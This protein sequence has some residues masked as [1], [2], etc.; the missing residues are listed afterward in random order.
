M[1]KTSRKSF[2]TSLTILALATEVNGASS[3]ARALLSRT[4]L[5]QFVSSDGKVE[6]V[7]TITGWSQ[8]RASIKT[9]MQ[10]VM[11][12]LPGAEKRCP[13]EMRVAQETDCGDYV[14]RFISYAAEPNGHVP[15]Y[16]LIPK[17][18]S[19]KAVKLPAILVLHQ[20]HP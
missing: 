20:T 10:E 5:L 18:A 6:S 11:G 9:A 3:A 19:T 14:R 15:A 16:L 1:S 7:R 8:R 4:N 12:P 13:L 2:A 17:Q